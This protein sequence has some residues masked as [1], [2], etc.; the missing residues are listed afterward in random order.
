MYS[1]AQTWGS[2]SG[3]GRSGDGGRRS[4]TVCGRTAADRAPVLADDSLKDCNDYVMN[5]YTLQFIDSKDGYDVI[6][7]KITACKE[8]SI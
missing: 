7:C 4:R 2:G 8:D 6:F 1:V 5:L 3:G